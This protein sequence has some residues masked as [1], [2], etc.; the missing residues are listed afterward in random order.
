FGLGIVTL[1]GMLFVLLRME[2][3]ALLLGAVALFA[4][5]A[6]IMMLTRQVDWY[7]RFK[8]VEAAKPEP[9]K[10]AV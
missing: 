10:A 6:A 1:Y 7:A 8:Q 4:V 3:T 5:L 2:Q 9:V